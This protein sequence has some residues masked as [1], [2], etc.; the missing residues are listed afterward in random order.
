VSLFQ[1]VFY[2]FITHQ[3]V[4]T[5]VVPWFIVNLVELLDGNLTIGATRCTPKP[6]FGPPISS[7]RPI[8]QPGMPSGTVTV[9]SDDNGI[10]PPATQVSNIPPIRKLERSQSFLDTIAETDVTPTPK[11]STT[12]FGGSMERVAHARTK[13]LEKSGNGMCFIGMS[14]Q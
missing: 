9:K 13:K 10:N 4:L 1:Y 5:L 8:P 6:L 3:Y 12:A 14:R 2:I 7:S 11:R